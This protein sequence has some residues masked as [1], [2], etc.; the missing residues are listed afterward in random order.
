MAI[1]NVS[2]WGL[3][4]SVPERRLTNADLEKMVDT[5]DEWIVTRTGIRERRIA[6]P[7][8]AT[9][10]L[11]TAAAWEALADAGVKPQEL[12]LIIVATVVPDMAFPATACLVQRNL[13]AIRAAAFDLEAACSGFVY[14]LTVGAQFVATG[15]Y[16]RVLVIGAEVLSRVVNWKDR[17]TCVLLGDGAGAVVLGPANGRRTLLSTYLGADGNGADV[18]K[19]PAGG[20]RLPASHDTVDQGLHYVFMNGNQVFKFAVR[21]MGA[22]IF[23]GLKKAGLSPADINVLVPHQANMRIIESAA[24]RFGLGMDRVVIN[25]DSYGNM[26]AASIPVA[27][28]EGVKGGRI[29][30]NDI[31][32]LVAFGGGLTWG[33]AVLRW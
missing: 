22:A 17:G 33:S 31:V 28:V 13:G 21:T 10:D 5:S 27:L 19:Q 25:L 2:I 14:A 12:D 3:G 16:H 23:A 30:E 6:A 24:E 18:L 29:K 26:S 9:S 11:A 32:V 4:M 20:S 7:E 8:E 15:T 1:N